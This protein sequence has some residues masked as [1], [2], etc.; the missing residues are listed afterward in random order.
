MFVFPE[1]NFSK[2]SRKI[3]QQKYSR[4]YIYTRVF[5]NVLVFK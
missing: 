1:N 4:V 3:S 5:L 2:I